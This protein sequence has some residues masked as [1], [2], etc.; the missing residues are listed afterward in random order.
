V[1]VIAIMPAYKEKSRIVAAISG[2][3]PMVDQIVVIDDGSG[4]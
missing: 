4:D 3:R 2:I 1:K